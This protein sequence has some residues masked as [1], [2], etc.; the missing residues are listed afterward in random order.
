MFDIEKYLFF[1]ADGTDGGGESTDVADANA[2]DDGADD[3]AGSGDADQDADKV[4]KD[5]DADAGSS[6][7]KGGDDDSPPAEMDWSDW[8]NQGAFEGLPDE[9]KESQALAEYALNA[10]KGKSDNEKFQADSKRLTELDGILKAQGYAGGINAIQPNFPLSNTSSDGRG[11]GAAEPPPLFSTDIVNKMVQNGEVE[12]VDADSY[13]HQARF[14]DQC[15]SGRDSIIA[16]G[17]KDLYAKFDAI[18]KNSNSNSEFQKQTEYRNFVQSYKGKI[19]AFPAKQLDNVRKTFPGI[20]YSK[21]QTFLLMENPD[22]LN[23]IL[24]NTE[25]KNKHVAKLRFGTE[26][27]GKK[28]GGSAGLTLKDFRKSDGTTDLNK[29]RDSIPKRADRKKLFAEFTTPAGK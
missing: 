2:G 24:A 10:Y 8:I 22:L 14:I 4:G 20:S 26:R 25:L 16:E 3:G 27:P 19:P 21:A 29:M 9:L 28:A 7:D 6:D 1:A 11:T 5:D 12:D 13:R 15:M 18:S 17:F 23:K